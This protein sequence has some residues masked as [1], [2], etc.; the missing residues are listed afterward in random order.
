MNHNNRLIK[1][2][3]VNVLL[4]L[5]VFS[6][7]GADPIPLTG[8]SSGWTA[9]SVQMNGAEVA[10]LIDLSGSNNSPAHSHRWRYRHDRSDH[11]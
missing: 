1:V 8:L 6:V 3:F 5:S 4:C 7:F 10:K 9:D 11:R 2:A